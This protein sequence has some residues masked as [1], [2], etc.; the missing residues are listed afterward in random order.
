MKD[1]KYAIRVRDSLFAYATLLDDLA[2]EDNRPILKSL[3]ND[4][5]TLSSDMR[6]R[7]DLPRLTNVAECLARTTR[8]CLD[9]PDDEIEDLDDDDKE[10]RE[11][12][13]N[14]VIRELRARAEH[15][16]FV[17]TAKAQQDWLA[18]AREQD[19]PQHA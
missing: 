1:V 3:V 19:E 13:V 6:N 15:F 11:D 10:R 5:E 8:R 18:W 7:E 14:S 12:C 9:L 16:H 17:L 4:L 2:V